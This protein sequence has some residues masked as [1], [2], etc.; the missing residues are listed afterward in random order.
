MNKYHK[1][2][3]DIKQA[4]KDEIHKKYLE[5]IEEEAKL[6]RM[7]PDERYKYL[8]EKQLKSM[9]AS[10]KKCKEIA[11]RLNNDRIDARM[12]RAEAYAQK[13]MAEMEANEAKRKA[14]EERVWQEKKRNKR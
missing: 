9:Q 7:T 5:R 8:S 14:Y 3:E 13:A 4:R 6:S 11:E 12:S 10:E 1:E 2:L